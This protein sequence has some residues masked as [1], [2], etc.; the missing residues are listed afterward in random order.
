MWRPARW[1]CAVFCA[2]CVLGC[3]TPPKWIQGEWSGYD[4]SPVT[5]KPTEYR[6]LFT[7]TDFYSIHG[8]DRV[9]LMYA[10]VVQRP[11]R[12]VIKSR[13]WF[14][15]RPSTKEFNKI[16]DDEILYRYEIGTGEDTYV[17]ATHLYRV[18]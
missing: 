14:S 16:G 18:K 4:L 6:Y 15:E 7:P 1:F 8:A 10:E 2:T 13:N 3:L 5:G 9:K 17:R 12:Y 11:D